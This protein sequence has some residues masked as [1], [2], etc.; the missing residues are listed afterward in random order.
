MKKSEFAKM[1]DATAVQ[2]NMEEKVVR[3]LLEIANEYEFK[4]VA[5]MHEFWPMAKEMLAEANNTETAFVGGAG[6]PDGT[7]STEEKL[8]E[9]KKGLA[10]GARE[11]DFSNNI[12]FIK[13]GKYD[14]M[15]EELKTLVSATEGC[16]TKVILETPKLTDEEIRRASEVVIE[17]GADFIK[18]A[19]GHNGPTT[20]EHV[21][22]IADAIKGKG[23]IQIKA[24]GGV[25]DLETVEE[26]VALGVTRFGIGIKTL[27]SI[28]AECED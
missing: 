1:V 15:L 28:L 4:A 25:R 19:T 13:E 17:S 18:T 23:E 9:I 5:V 26:M 16:L 22:V 6:F 12:N 8:E 3:E 24:A 14:L 27:K 20:I 21:K 7:C 10:F 2:Y 11:F